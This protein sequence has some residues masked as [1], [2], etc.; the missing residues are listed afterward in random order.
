MDYCPYVI[1]FEITNGCRNVTMNDVEPCSP[2]GENYG[3]NSRCVEGTYTEEGFGNMPHL[4]AGC[5]EIDCSGADTII[6]TV[7]GQ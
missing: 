5:H 7:G 4:H 3:A 2:Y 6:I 1:P